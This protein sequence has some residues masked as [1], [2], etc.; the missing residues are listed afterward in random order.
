[1][2]LGP[3]WLT[4]GGSVLLAGALAGTAGFVKGDAYGAGK[5]QAKWDAQQAKDRLAIDSANVAAQAAAE[6]YEESKAKRITRTVVVT[7]EV[8]HA[9]EAAPAWRDV[10]LPDGVRDAVAAAAAEADPAQP[11]GAVPLQPAGG[12]DERAAGAGLRLEPRRAGG[13]LGAPQGTR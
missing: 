11:H 12:Q 10:A 7:K 9:L 3:S 4:F 5:V 1:V 2:I 13:L 6:L 8:S